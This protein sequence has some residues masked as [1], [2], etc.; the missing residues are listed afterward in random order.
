MSRT[1]FRVN[2][3][4]IVCLNIKELLVQSRRHIWSLS[5]GNGIQTYN[6]LVRK[7]TLDHVAK[8]AQFGQVVECSFTNWVVV[9]SNSVSVI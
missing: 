2:P 8:L 3:H 9:G 6:H 5:D 7:Q 4:S 1:S